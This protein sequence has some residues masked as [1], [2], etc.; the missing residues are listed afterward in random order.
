MASTGNLPLS[1]VKWP[2][3]YSGISTERELHNICVVIDP[4]DNTGRF[5]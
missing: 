5:V 1:H 2:Q 3:T 4:R